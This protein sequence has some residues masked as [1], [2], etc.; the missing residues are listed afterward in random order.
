MA[1]PRM[2]RY[3]VNGRLRSESPAHPT[4]KWVVFLDGPH[5]LKPADLVF[6]S[7]PQSLEETGEAVTD[8]EMA[9]RAWGLKPTPENLEPGL[10][11]A[12]EAIKDALSKDTYVGVFGFSQGAGMA[13]TVAALLEKPHL[14][15]PFVVDGKPIHPPLEFCVSTA[16]YLP[17]GP[18]RTPLFTPSYSTPTLHILGRTDVVVVE[19]RSNQLIEVSANQRV[20]YHPGGHFVPAQKPWRDFFRAWMIDPAADAPSP[21][22]PAPD[23]QGMGQGP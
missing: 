11:D 9:P 8:P 13:A 1:T 18:I 22:P 17:S 16:G 23:N 5:I 3:S 12:L 10:V 7:S 20:E 6:G 2:R 19:E 14:Y 4:S 15:P 21:I